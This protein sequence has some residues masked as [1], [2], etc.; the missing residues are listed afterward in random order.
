MCIPRQEKSRNPLKSGQGFLHKLMAIEQRYAR[1]KA[2]S[3]SPQIGS[4]FL[5]GKVSFKPNR[6]YVAMSQSPRIG[7]MFLTSDV[8]V[9]ICWV[10]V[11]NVAIPSNR[12]NVSYCTHL[13]LRIIGNLTPLLREPHY[14]Y[15][16]FFPI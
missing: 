2:E 10:G 15:A 7:S 11:L 13:F 1:V 5:T 3:Q 14:F 9:L 6:S 8:R 12:V 16:F 4:R